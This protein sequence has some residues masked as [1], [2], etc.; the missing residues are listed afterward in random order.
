MANMSENTPLPIGHELTEGKVHHALT[1]YGTP[2][3]EDTVRA[4]ALLSA[5]P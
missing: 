1:V 3:C 2:T 4:R 5:G